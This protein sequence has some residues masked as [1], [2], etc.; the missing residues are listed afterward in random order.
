MT[1]KIVAIHGIG[2]TFEGEATLKPGWLQALRVGL[3]EAGAAPIED[4]DFS[5]VAYGALFRPPGS[6][7][8]GAVPKLDAKDVQQ[9]LEQELLTQWWQAAAE[10]SAASRQ[11]TS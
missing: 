10:Q 2:Q 7:R 4:D 8:S 5:M 9:G 6:K 11:T 3:A 1:M